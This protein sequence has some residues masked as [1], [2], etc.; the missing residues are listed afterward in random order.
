V[1]LLDQPHFIE[2]KNPKV[3]SYLSEQG[4]VVKRFEARSIAS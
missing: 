1:C 3:G 2:D 4:I